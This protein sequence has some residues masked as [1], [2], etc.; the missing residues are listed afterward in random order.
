[1]FKPKKVLVWCLV[2][3]AAVFPVAGQTSSLFAQTTG[4]ITGTVVGIDG[5]PLRGIKVEAVDVAT[6]VVAASTTTRPDG[7]FQF[8]GL[9]AGKT[10]RIQAA[11]GLDKASEYVQLSPT[12]KQTS[13]KLSKTKGFL[14]PH[15]GQW[16]YVVVGVL[17]AAGVGLGAAAAT[18]AIGGGGKDRVASP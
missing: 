2:L 10:Y 5:K 4:E 7:S 17:A 15:P 6:D 14:S 3:L 13:L 9:E 11:H 8:K 18:G 12:G 1:M 16:V